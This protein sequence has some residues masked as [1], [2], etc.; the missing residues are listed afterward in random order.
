MRFPTL[1]KLLRK[2]PRTAPGERIYAVGDIHGCYGLFVEL[3]EM[4]AE[5]NAALPPA[6]SKMILLGDIIDRGPDSKKF[7][8][9]LVNK[10]K[11]GKLNI[12]CGNHEAAM[13]AAIDGDTHALNG[14][15][16]QGG[17]ETLE[18]LGVLPPQP[19]EDTVDFSE[20][21]KSEISQDIVTALRNMPLS[22]RS[23]D[24]L[25]VHAGIRPGIALNEQDAEDLLWIRDEFL[26][27]EIDHGP[28]IVHGH[29]I[30]ET[31]DIRY[32]RI[33]VDTGAWKTGRLSAICLDG[34]LQFPMSVE[35]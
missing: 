7:L 9:I 21:L 15:L 12:L 17:I 35:A 33:A 3:L 23:G 31:V 24:Y 14:W 10:A 11:M 2:P 4:I 27:S 5:H 6:R 30:V 1:R 29:S 18:S 32:N 28:V 25:F 16:S 22:L 34:E 20:R 19:G 26:E 8:R 13:L